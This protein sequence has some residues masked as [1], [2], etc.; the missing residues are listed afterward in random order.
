MSCQKT[1][2]MQLS[3]YV[4]VFEERYF[5][6]VIWFRRW[7]ILHWIKK[8]SNTCLKCCVWIFSTWTKTN[9]YSLHHDSYKWFLIFWERYLSVFPARLIRIDLSRHVMKVEFYGYQRKGVHRLK[10][11]LRV[12]MGLG[13]LSHLYAISFSFSIPSTY[14]MLS[15]TFAFKS[16]TMDFFWFF[17]SL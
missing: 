10:W 1:M 13:S 15:K 4:L 2:F 5:I 12:F 16:E 6:M 14:V 3:W 8:R 17:F 7:S 11:C 9:S